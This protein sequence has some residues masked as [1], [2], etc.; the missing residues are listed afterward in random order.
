MPA[1]PDVFTGEFTIQNDRIDYTAYYYVPRN[2]PQ[3]SLLHHLVKILLDGNSFF[4]SLSRLVYGTE[5]WHIEMRSRIMIDSVVN[6]HNY[7]DHSYLM[8]NATDI[9]MECIDICEYY[10]SYSG[11]ANVGKRDAHAQGIQLVLRDDIMRI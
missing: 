5:G 2:I 9:H 1:L 7:T 3:Q 10:C 4:R 6:F 11:V 8:Q